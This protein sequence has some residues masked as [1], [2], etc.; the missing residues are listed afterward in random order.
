[1]ILSRVCLSLNM[2]QNKYICCRLD[3]QPL[4]RDFF[5]KTKRE[6]LFSLILSCFAQLNDSY[7]ATL[8]S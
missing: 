4:K 7:N 2:K 3:N 1:M 6:Y 8:F 5:K